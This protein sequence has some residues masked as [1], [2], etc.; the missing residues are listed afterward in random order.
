MH[1]YHNES[2]HSKAGRG[3][4]LNPI[5]L[6]RTFL[7]EG[8]EIFIPA[9]HVGKAG[10]ALDICAKIPAEDM[11]SF[12]EKWTPEKRL[13]LEKPENFELFQAEN[14]SGQGFHVEMSL[15]G[16]SLQNGMS[17]SLGWYP[18]EV[19]RA[20]SSAED[21]ENDDRGEGWEDGGKAEDWENDDCASDWKNNDYAEELMEAYKR[22][23]GC[24]WQFTRF[25]FDWAKSPVLSP[26]NICL[27]FKADRISVTTEHFS[28]NAFSENEIPATIKTFHPRTGKEYTLTLYG[29][30]QSQADFENTLEDDMIY[31]DYYQE[32]YYHIS[33]ETTPDLIAVRDCAESE[34]ARP[35]GETKDAGG[36]D[37]PTAVFIA[38]TLGNPGFQKAAS[39]LHFEPI[40]VVNW[41]IVFQIKPKE[42]MEIRL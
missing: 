36:S 30:R 19:L 34:P 18:P 3:A 39:A 13:S 28:T 9:V 11:I 33:P 5:P 22:D 7:W 15:D 1:L 23:K 16:V 12:L 26:K 25:S 20:E 27:T 38:G 4:K 2:I 37:G 29:C 17:S 10:A 24:C 42:D 14:P 6:N 21:W 32:L 31:P 35:S 40:P 41:R 8:Q